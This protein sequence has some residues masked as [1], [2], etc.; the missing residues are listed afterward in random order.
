MNPLLTRKGGCA[1]RK[2]I[3]YAIPWRILVF[4][5]DIGIFWIFDNQK[6]EVLKRRLNKKTGKGVKPLPVFFILVSYILILVYI[7]ATPVFLAASATAAAT[8]FPTLGSN[9]AEE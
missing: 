4:G 1:W 8:V 2:R 7:L 6:K 5:K 9:G 3:L